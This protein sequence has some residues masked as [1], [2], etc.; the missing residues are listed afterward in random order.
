MM[1][2]DRA[3]R[4][5]IRADLYRYGGDA[6]WRNFVRQFVRTPGFRF[7]FYLRKLA[8][9]RGKRGPLAR[10][11][12]AYNRVLF[13]HISMRC[14]FDISPATVIGPG[15]Y[16]G[17]WGGIYVSHQAVIGSNVNIAR[18]ATIGPE[19]RGKRKGAPTIGDRV[20]IGTYAIVVGN[21]RVGDD[22]LI[23]P[24]AFVNFDVPSSSVVI[25]NPG[26]IVSDRGSAGY[27]NN[28]PTSA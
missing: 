19:S 15:L 8:A 27:V 25:G 24:G 23:A 3:T 5:N 2:L 6:S 12:Y 4:R 7:T 13:W 18:G 1:L 21:I 28:V 26:K 14:N 22:A 11:A 10:L 17:H 9:L 20:W 16:V